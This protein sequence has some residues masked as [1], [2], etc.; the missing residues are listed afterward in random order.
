M[1]F[2]NVA[3][4]GFGVV[5]DKGHSEALSRALPS[6]GMNSTYIMCNDDYVVRVRKGFSWFLSSRQCVVVV[7]VVTLCETVVAVY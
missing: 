7:V 4:S 1:F 3:S 5:S 6:K 2:S